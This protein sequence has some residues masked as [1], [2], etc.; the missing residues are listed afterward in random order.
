M[1]NN[2]S[3]NNI[4][5]RGIKRLFFLDRIF[6]KISNVLKEETFFPNLTSVFFHP[7]YIARKGLV[8]DI[9]PL[10]KYIKGRVLDVGC[11]SK[12]YENIFY[13][14][15]EY[16]GVDTRK[17]GHNHINEEI[18]IYY[19][20]KTL[21]FKNNEFDSVVTFEVL[22]H[23]FNPNEFIE[24]ISRVLKNGGFLLL[25]VPFV[26]DEHEQPYDFARYTS[27]GLSYLLKKNHFDIIKYKRTANDIRIIFQLVNAYI[28][29]VL[30]KKRFYKHRYLYLIANFMLMGPFNI[31][32]SILAKIFPKNNDLY[33]DSIILAKKMQNA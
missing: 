18:D 30:Y 25:T 15:S 6:D 7:F 4:L 3:N 12:P 22:E 14:A 13:M 29:K 17:S 20:G 11:G 28:F 23:V 16:I 2:I 32:G 26:W 19:D 33:L 5:V 1:K 27:F 10:A 8:E 24:E 21:P 9:R 31:L